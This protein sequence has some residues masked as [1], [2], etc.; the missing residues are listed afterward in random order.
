MQNS[1]H[2][3]E[4]KIMLWCLLIKLRYLVARVFGE[5]INAGI[6]LFIVAD[7]LQVVEKIVLSL[8]AGRQGKRRLLRFV[9]RS[10][11]WRDE[12]GMRR[13]IGRGLFVPFSGN[14][15]LSESQTDPTSQI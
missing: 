13:S 15:W 1:K 12:G 9:D 5:S 2:T 4:K 7:Y 14:S 10:P 8:Y 6:P 3:S 11:E